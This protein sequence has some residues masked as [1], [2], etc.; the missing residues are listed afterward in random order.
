MIMLVAGAAIAAAAT[1][2]TATTGATAA[3]G[4]GAG[5]CLLSCSLKRSQ[6]ATVVFVVMVLT[7]AFVLWL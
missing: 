4:G 7:M 2:S 3:T 5:G 6:V 1:D